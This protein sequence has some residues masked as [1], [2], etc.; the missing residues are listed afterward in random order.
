MIM[1]KGILDYVVMT[2]KLEEK[3]DR[4]RKRQKMTE[5]KC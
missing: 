1:R 4:G 3:A 5:R 2:G